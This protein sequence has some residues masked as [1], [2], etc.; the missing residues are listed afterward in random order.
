MSEPPTYAG[1]KTDDGVRLFARML[2]E[3]MQE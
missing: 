3:G 2:Y 1:L